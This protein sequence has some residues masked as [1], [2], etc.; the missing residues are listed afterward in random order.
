[1]SMSAV[2]KI[3]C[4]RNTRFEVS[5][6]NFLTFSTSPLM[7]PLSPAAPLMTPRIHHQK[8]KNKKAQD[9]QNDRGGLSFPKQLD[10]FENFTEI[11]A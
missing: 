11:H 1:L 9:E 4:A 5:R 8:D 10:I 3:R 6:F 2:S 7:Q